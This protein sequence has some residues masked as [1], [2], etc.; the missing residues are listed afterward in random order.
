MQKFTN[1]K[2]LTVTGNTVYLAAGSAGLFAF[3]ISNPNAPRLE[4]VINLHGDLHAVTVYQNIIIAITRQGKLWLLNRVKNK[5][6][7]HHAVIDTLGIGYD[8]VPFG[9]R[10]IIANG[11]KGLTIL[12]LPQQ[13]EIDNRAITSGR[14]DNPEKISLRIPPQA[15]PGVYNLNLL[16]QGELIEFVGAVE[17]RDAAE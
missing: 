17:L 7:T 8:L 6:T 14:T 2:Q 3:D 12:P 13:L 15:N 10:I 4:E 9:N 5:T 11:I 1:I 16:H